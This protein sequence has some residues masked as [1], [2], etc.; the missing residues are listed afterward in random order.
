MSSSLRC[1]LITRLRALPAV[2]TCYDLDS[3]RSIFSVNAFLQQLK[4][5]SDVWYEGLAYAGRKEEGRIHAHM[6]C[7]SIQAPF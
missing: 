1:E 2:F 6:D 7:G 4:K 5:L 3:R